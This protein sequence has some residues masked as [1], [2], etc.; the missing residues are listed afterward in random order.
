MR[1]RQQRKTILVAAVFRH[2]RSSS[3][4]V[5]GFLDYGSWLA[6]LLWGGLATIAMGWCP[7]R[8]QPV[9]AGRVASINFSR[10]LLQKQAARAALA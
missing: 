5:D 1:P 7:D 3:R 8:S 6:L 10:G 2:G 9:P 4:F